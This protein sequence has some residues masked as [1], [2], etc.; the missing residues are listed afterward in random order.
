M[1][2]TTPMRAAFAAAAVLLGSACGGA[3][4]DAGD[5]THP[6]AGRARVPG[7]TQLPAP[8]SASYGAKACLTAA[9]P[10]ALSPIATG[11]RHG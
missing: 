4:D 1:S 2:I 3:G 7:C 6:T 9:K 11:A 5:P 10:P 8:D